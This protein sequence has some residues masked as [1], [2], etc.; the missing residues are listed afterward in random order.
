MN[1]LLDTCVISEIIKQTPSAKV[2]KWIK[3][4]SGVVLL[5][6]WE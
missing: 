6:P 5:N 3:K 1:Y 4:E 2:T